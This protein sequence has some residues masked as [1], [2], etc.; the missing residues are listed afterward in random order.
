MSEP[1]IYLDG[2]RPSASIAE[3]LRVLTQDWINSGEYCDTTVLDLVQALRW[4]LRLKLSEVE[5]LER[6]E[7]DTMMGRLKILDRRVAYLEER[8]GM[9]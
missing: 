4:S 7:H 6:S 9:G 3:A 5:E 2:A 1:T 8:E